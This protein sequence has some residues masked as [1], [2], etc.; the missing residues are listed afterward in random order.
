[1]YLAIDGGGTKTEYLLLDEDFHIVSQYL[2][3]GT[4]HDSI[5]GGW[6]DVGKRLNDGIRRV[7][8]E[9]GVHKLRIRDVAAGISSLD[10]V[11]DEEHCRECF[12]KVGFETVTLVND[13]FLPV[14]ANGRDGIG[15]AFNCGTGVCC[16]GI[17]HAGNHV[18]LGGLDDWSGDAGGGTWIIMNVYRTLYERLIYSRRRTHFVKAFF[19][20]LQLS[21]EEDLINYWSVLKDTDTW[22][23]KQIAQGTPG[24]EDAGIIAPS[25]VRKEIIRLFFEL[26]ENGDKDALKIGK[27]MQNYF[28]NTIKAADSRLA[29]DERVEKNRPIPL[30]LCGSVLTQAAG[31]KYLS[32]LEN[33]IRRLF[34]SRFSV[35]KAEHLPVH[36]AVVMLKMKQQMNAEKKE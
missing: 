22:E 9:A 32:E 5:P 18:K 20:L 17:D 3:L 16:A 28:R 1:M 29:F 35:V 4:N 7:L 23:T 14:Y 15:I 31:R 36:G 33:E 8:S 19:Q 11:S 6:K 34:G 26:Y 12:R 2:G 27:Q 25:V 21:T 10:T 24:T 13:G 30:I